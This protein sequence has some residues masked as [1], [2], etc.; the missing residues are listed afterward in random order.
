VTTLEI[1]PGLSRQARRN[2][3]HR[4]NVTVIQGDGRVPPCGVAF[5]KV[6]FGFALPAIPAAYVDA[7][8]DK[9]VIVAPV[10]DADGQVLTRVVRRNGRAVVSYHGP[11]RY[12]LAR[13]VETSL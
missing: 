5:R 7:L 9:G 11:V 1:D 8:P 12:V 3:R 10:G 4:P 13:S 2:L 6:L